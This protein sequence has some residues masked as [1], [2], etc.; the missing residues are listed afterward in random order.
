LLDFE[1]RCYRKVIP[2]AAVEAKSWEGRE[3]CPDWQTISGYLAGRL[4]DAEFVTIERHFGSCPA[5]QAMVDRA[6]ASDSVG[7]CLQTVVMQAAEDGAALGATIDQ[8]EII[9]V[10]GCGGMGVV[11]RARHL[12]LGHEVALKCLSHARAGTPE[13]QDRFLQEIR[14]AAALAHPNIVR[15]EHAGKSADGRL[16]LVMELLHG[17]TLDQLV[18]ERGALPVAHACELARQV[19]LGLAHVHERGLIHR[20]IKPSNLMLNHQGVV[21]VLDLGL[22]RMQGRT[23]VDESGVTVSREVV[24]T[25][26]F[27]APEQA[28]DPRSVDA[29]S[30]LYSLGCTLYYLLTAHKLF[31]GPEYT[32]LFAKLMGHAQDAYPPLATR[33]PGLPAGLEALVDRLLAKKPGDRPASAQEV[34]HALASFAAGA[35]VLDLLDAG[36]RA[37]PV[38]PAAPRR[39]RRLVAGCVAL[40]LLLGLA[41]WLRQTNALDRWGAWLFQAAPGKEPTA[42]AQALQAWLPATQ[43]PPE[44]RQAMGAALHAT[45]PEQT[46]WTGEAK[47]WAFALA[48]RRVPPKLP[49]PAVQGFRTLAHAAAVQELVFRHATFAA[50]TKAGLSDDK[51]LRAALLKC[52]DQFPLHLKA[53]VK[54][55]LHQTD[56]RDGVALAYVAA[57]AHGLEAALV[58]GPVHKLVRNAY[59]DVA[60][61]QA[62]Q[63]MT[64]KR[65]K[66]ALLLWKHVH[67]RQLATPA[68]NLDASRW[69]ASLGQGKEALAL[70]RATVGEA[71]IAGTPLLLE[72]L[73]DV[74]F[75][76][77][78]ASRADDAELAQAADAVAREAYEA[79][80][81]RLGTN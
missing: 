7:E 9:R 78:E 24:G 25:A 31:E 2:M 8:Y 77:R 39:S 33:R 30:D 18:Q 62:R 57:P 32:T 22:C 48:V 1:K 74:A 10:L 35:N 50:Y 75:A 47:E 52:S 64:G 79:A 58:A 66:E 11:Y 6:P 59:Q 72:E 3:C 69:L 71:K 56:V 27:M 21:K 5:C 54:G 49:D 81:R 16:F 38:Q 36:G 76:L 20:D 13:S 67:D 45:T 53:T 43:A 23:L 80:L 60:H 70:L 55:L 63:H 34:A 40:V 37:A 26:D 68:F 17:K 41:G 19:C 73:G 29:R 42:P 61:E 65:W 44:L 12:Y 14:G 28:R 51:L 15:V 46:A 4:A